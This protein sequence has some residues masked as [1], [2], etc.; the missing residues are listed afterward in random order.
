VYTDDNLAISIDPLAISTRLNKYFT[1]KPDYMHPQD[2]YLGTKLKEMVLPNGTKAWGQSSSHYIHNA[3]AYLEA[4]MNDKEYKLPR[5]A[6]GCKLSTRSWCITRVRCRARKLL[7]IVDGVLQWIT[8]IGCLNI[9][10]KVLMLATHMEMPRE[11]HLY[12]VFRVFAYL[13]ANYNARRVYDP[14]YPRIHHQ[15][16]K[17]NRDVESN[18]WRCSQNNPT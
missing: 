16:F 5:R 17:A 18:L 13:K 10:T 11:W 15:K 6:H 3:L 14:T 4:W 12:A 9:K 8:E 2:D 7:S 1:L